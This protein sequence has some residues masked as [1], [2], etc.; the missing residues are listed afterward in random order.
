MRVLDLPPC[1]DCGSSSAFRLPSP[2]IDMPQSPLA[3]AQTSFT[4]QFIFPIVNNLF[5]PFPWRKHLIVRLAVGAPAICFKG[6]SIEEVDEAP[7]AGSRH[8]LHLCC[9]AANG[10]RR[11]R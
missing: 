7:L 9:A 5:E 2:V 8:F 1:P 10:M 6:T 4:G 3:I 11:G